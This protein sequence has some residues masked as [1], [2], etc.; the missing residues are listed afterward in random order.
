MY[1]YK[2]RGDRYMAKKDIVDF[3]KT[4]INHR[5]E[6]DSEDKERPIKLERATQ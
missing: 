5:E 2:I 4:L 3:E 6:R 1:K